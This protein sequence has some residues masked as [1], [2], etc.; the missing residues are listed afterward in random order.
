[1][2]GRLRRTTRLD[3][4]LALSF[5]GIA[6]LFWA[7]AAG[8]GRALGHDLNQTAGATG[9]ELSRLGRLVT[10][11]FVDAGI[12]IDLV[13]LLWMVVSLFLVLYSSRQRLSISWAWVSAVCQS[14]AAAVFAVLTAGACRPFLVSAPS[15]APG[16]ALSGEAGSLSL[17]VTMA[18]A[19]VVWVTFLVVLIMERVRLGR[20]GPTLRDGLRTH[21][22]R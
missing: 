1:M 6:Y 18:V 13:G 15:P 17:A 10:A 19:I 14:F 11:A 12:L 9:A 21:V 16:A 2:L 22:N 5:A 20:R 8:V 4:G 3:V 7:L